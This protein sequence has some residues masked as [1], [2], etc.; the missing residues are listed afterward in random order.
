MATPL[1]RLALG[2]SQG[3]SKLQ[4]RFT[5]IEFKNYKALERF[6]VAL[7]EFNVLVGPNNAGKSTILGAL[8]ILSEGMRKAR[9]RKPEYIS[10][11]AINGLGYH[12]PLSDLPVATENIFTNYDDSEPATIEFTLLSGN[13]LRLIFPE[14]DV[15]YMVCDAIRKNVKSPADF[16]REYN[17]SVGFVPILGPVEHNEQLYQKE[18]ARKA[19]LTHKASRN[20]R[21]IWYHYPNKFDQFRKM[22]QSTWP[23]MDIEKPEIDSS[24]QKL[25][26][27]MYCPEE[28]FPREIFWAG[29]GFQVWCQMLTYIVRSG[30]DS[31]LIIDEPDIYLHSDLQR[32]L[33]EILRKAPSDILIATHST[34]IISEADPG[35]LLVIDKKNRSARRVKNP[36]QLQSIFGVLG[37]NL[38]PTLTQL[39][40]SR[41]AIFVEGKDFQI[42]SA[43]ARKTGHQALANRS[44][45]AVIP[46]EGF[47]PSKVRDSSQGIELA[48]GEELIKAVIFDRDYRS[49]QEVNALVKEFRK[50]ARL[51]HIHERKEIENYLI[52]PSAIRRAI[53]KR[54]GQHSGR[55]GKNI[56]FNEDIEHILKDLSDGLKSKVMAQFI[57]KRAEYL[58]VENRGLDTATINQMMLEDFDDSWS[59]FNSRLKLVPGKAL[60]SELNGYLQESYEISISNAL[61]LDVMNKNEIPEEVASLI[62]RLEEFRNENL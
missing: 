23:G 34:E 18:A 48:L 55:T 47:N 22:I 56:E 27:H 62:T 58:K 15:C 57:S 25:V 17:A 5:R 21:N 3:K 32:Q 40:K 9:S 53:D 4:D 8:R 54:I 46:V 49:S 29:F 20:F 42:L 24:Y 37:S 61:I 30:D 7:H 43:F 44:D 13:K 26:L 50:F 31:L 33:L 36:S 14:N 59:D 6:S 16:K 52:V 28:R 51:A 11:A 39:A 19:L 45:F 35:D 10:H 1:F 38:N 41:R 2:I 12:V 60:L